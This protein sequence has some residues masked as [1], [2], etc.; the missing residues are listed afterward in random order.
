MADEELFRTICTHRAVFTPVR[1]VGYSELKLSNLNILPAGDFED[2][3]KNDY[4]AMR[5]NM[6]YG[7]SPEFEELIETVRKILL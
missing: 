5:E 4:Q 3:Y 6:I 2:S 7:E 1:G